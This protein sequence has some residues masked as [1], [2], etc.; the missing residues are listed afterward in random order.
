[1]QRLRVRRLW[2]Q[3]LCAGT[4]GTRS[5]FPSQTIIDVFVRTRNVA[6]HFRLTGQNS[7]IG[8]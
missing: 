8:R 2:A 6:L 7:L 3:E 1:M 5:V 4:S